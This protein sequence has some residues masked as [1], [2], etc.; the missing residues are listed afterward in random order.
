MRDRDTLLKDFENIKIFC[1]Y[2]YL[3]S[4]HSVIIHNSIGVP[5]RIRMDENLVFWCQNM[6]FP[7][8]PESCWSEELTLRKTLSVIEGLKNEPAI[9]FPKR[10]SN[11]W[12]EIKSICNM[13]VVQNMIDSR[14]LYNEEHR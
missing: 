7:N 8:I 4:N 9:D 11:R 3:D 10:F 14:R 2:L 5:L 6:N 1:Q 13:N 12:E